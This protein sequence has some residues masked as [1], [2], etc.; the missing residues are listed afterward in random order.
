MNRQETQRLR[1]VSHTLLSHPAARRCTNKQF[2]W[3]AR[4]VLAL[5][6]GGALFE[7]AEFFAWRDY[8]DHYHN[9]WPQLAQIR[10]GRR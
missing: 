6:D 3:I 5:L 9:T 4:R 1:G 10:K 8:E 2:S 7:H